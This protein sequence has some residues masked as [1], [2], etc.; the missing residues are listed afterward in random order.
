MEYRMKKKARKEYSVEM[1]L[2]ICFFMAGV[3]MLGIGLLIG[4]FTWQRWSA[5][6]EVTGRILGVYSSDH[7]RVEV[8]Y[9]YRGEYYEASLSEYSSSMHE[10]DAILLLIRAD[11]PK[12]VRTKELLYLPSFILGIIMVPFL[13][14]GAVFL[15]IWRKKKNRRLKLIQTGR[16]IYAVVTG[17]EINFTIRINGRHPYKWTCSGTAPDGTA[18]VFYS[19]NTMTIPSAYVGQ[20]VEVW[21]DP[22]DYDKYYVN[23]AG[24]LEAL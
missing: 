6:E 17:G 9:T 10:G 8:A 14:I 13:I 18:R 7:A 20:N 16:R 23:V 21:I 4:I 5:A 3:L 12:K 1:L 22:S 19:E 11:D 15:I 24:L 2:G